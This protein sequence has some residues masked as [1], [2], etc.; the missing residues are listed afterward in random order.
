MGKREKAADAKAVLFK[1]LYGV[2][3]DT[4]EKMRGILQ[5]AYEAL[6]KQG[7]KPPKLT[8]QDKL[9]ITLKY[10]REYRTME[11]IGAGYEAGKS[12]ACES[13]QWVEDA[14]TKDKTFRLPDKK[15][16]KKNISAIEYIAADVTESPINSPKQPERLV[17]R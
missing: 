14:M 3:P 17:F 6:H 5:K 10:L 2:K 7:G 9:R 4:F 8:V 12:A 1:R 11:S 16:L 15:A 13:L